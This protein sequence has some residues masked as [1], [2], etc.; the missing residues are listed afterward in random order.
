VLSGLR[1]V[2]VLAE[3]VTTPPQR[4]ADPKI[5]IVRDFNIANLPKIGDRPIFRG[6]VENGIDRLNR[7]ACLEKKTAPE[8]N[9]L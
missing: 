2:N 4:S 5:A 8:F 7:Q 6:N 1:V 3:V 9:F